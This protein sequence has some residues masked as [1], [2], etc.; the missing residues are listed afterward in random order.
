MVYFFL[1]V[2]VGQI[3]VRISHINLF[4][5]LINTASTVALAKLMKLKADRYKWDS[6]RSLS[7]SSMSSLLSH[8]LYQRRFMP[9]YSFCTLAGLDSEG[10]GAVYKYDA[11]GSCEKVTATCCGKAE[12]LIQPLLDEISDLEGDD[13]LWEVNPTN[14]FFFLLK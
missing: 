1:A 10:R 5:H 7:I 9:Y 2:D 4:Q 6:L 14:I 13:A 11:I 3:L 8:T 12:H